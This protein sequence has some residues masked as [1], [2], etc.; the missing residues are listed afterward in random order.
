MNT[1]DVEKRVGE[2]EEFAKAGAVKEAKELEYRLV[3]DVLQAIVDYD[4]VNIEGCCELA[5]SA[6]AIDLKDPEPPFMQ[7]E[8][9]AKV[10]K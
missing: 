3:L 6:K 5:I 7:E 1:Q 10:K 8:K 9:P 2:I 4:C